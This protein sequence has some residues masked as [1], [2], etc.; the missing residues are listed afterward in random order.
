MD[1]YILNAHYQ[2]SCFFVK[3]MAG[4]I[5]ACGANVAVAAR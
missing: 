2:I 5:D 1:V 3:M 4:G